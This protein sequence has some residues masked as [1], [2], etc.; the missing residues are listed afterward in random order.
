M[1]VMFVISSYFEIQ[2]PSFETKKTT[3]HLQRRTKTQR[4]LPRREAHPSSRT[5]MRNSSADHGLG[6]QENQQIP[7]KSQETI[8]STIK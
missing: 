4:T 8:L 3:F 5:A 2:K 7:R 6:F 1:I